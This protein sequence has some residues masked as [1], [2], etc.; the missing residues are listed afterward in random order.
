M[1]KLELLKER[2]KQNRLILF[3]NGVHH[4]VEIPT[5]NLQCPLRTTKNMHSQH[6]LR[7]PAKT[8]ILKFSFL[9]NTVKD[10]NLLPQDIINK[11]ESTE[12]PAKSLIIIN[13][14]NKFFIYRELHS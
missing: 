13:N 14:N 1:T 8:D 5:D 4:L 7:L 3:C 11:V 9:L 12:D 6:Y 2:R 10:W